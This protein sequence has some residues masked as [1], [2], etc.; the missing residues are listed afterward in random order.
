M[1]QNVI[2]T[3]THSVTL[4]GFYMSKYL[5]T[6]ELY[7]AVM[8]NNPSSF[9]GA[10]HPPAAGETQG[11]R[12]VEMVS[13]FDALVFCNTLSV[14][15]G[16]TPVYSIKSSTDP[17]A[18][19]DVPTSTTHE[20]YADWNAVTMA[21]SANGYRLPTE[22][23]WEYACR[24]GTTTA[25]STG[26]T[27]SEADAWYSAN[28]ESR[29]REV[30]KKPANPW[31]LFDMHGNVWEWVWDWYADY[32]DTAKENPTGPDTGVTRMIRGGSW[33]T[34]DDRQLRSAYR[35]ILDQS[36]QDD[37]IGFRVVRNKQ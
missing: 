2:A 24:A 4:S 11:K 14:Q 18:W 35:N 17:A 37:S 32:T 10:E 26:D 30:G 25:Y 28:S 27:I 29:T 9:Q 33:S 19:G 16:L 21:V 3:P 8:G 31:G 12:P 15:D 22:A 6:Q 1:G 7:Q 13:W 34:V 5:V 20:N 36:Y 23:E